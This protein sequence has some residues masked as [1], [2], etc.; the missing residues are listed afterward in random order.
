MPPVREPSTKPSAATVLPAPVACSNQKRLPA[1]GSSGALGQLRRRRP[2]RRARP[3]QSCGSSGSSSSSSRSSSPGIAARGERRVGAA[4]AAPSTPVA[5]GACGLGQQ[6]GQRARQRVD[7]VGG[8]HRAVGELA[9]PPAQ[10][11]RSRPSSS[12][13]RCRQATDG[14]SRAGLELRQRV[15]ERAAARRCRARARRRRPRPS[16]TNGSRV[17]VAAR[18]MSS[19]G[20]MAGAASRATDVESAMTARC[21]KG[22]GAA[23]GTAARLRGCGPGSEAWSAEG[24]EARG[25]S[26]STSIEADARGAPAR[27][28]P[29]YGA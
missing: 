29:P 22:V 4:A 9:A 15:V 20:G 7:L 14:T 18:S 5:V 28:L 13:Q 6:R 1:F 27:D 19:A 2:R 21:D 16:S 11:S 3:S 12:D 26:A 23:N 10:S 8:E 24:P 17:N 25:G